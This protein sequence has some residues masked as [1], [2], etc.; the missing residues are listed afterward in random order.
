MDKT[1]IGLLAGAMALALVG[2]VESAAAASDVDA[3]ALQRARPFAELLAPSPHADG[4][5]AGRT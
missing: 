1:M 5:P 4:R 3:N 2:G